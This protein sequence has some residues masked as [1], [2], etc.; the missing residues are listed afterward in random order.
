MYLTAYIKFNL[1]SIRYMRFPASLLFNVESN[2]GPSSYLCNFFPIAICVSTS[3]H[4]SIVNLF[5]ISITYFCWHL[6]MCWEDFF[7]SIPKKFFMRPQF[8]IL[9]SLFVEAFNSSNIV[10]TIYSMLS[11]PRGH[12]NWKASWKWS[13]MY[14]AIWGS[15]P[16]YLLMPV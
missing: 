11:S 15:N 7:N 2:I 9:S 10:N 1:V 4:L 8:S 16:H 5:N 14:Q 13:V 6:K 12:L 3:F